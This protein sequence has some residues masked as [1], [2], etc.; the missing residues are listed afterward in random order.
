[1]L[2]V[3]WLRSAR[4]SSRGRTRQVAK[5][6]IVLTYSESAMPARCRMGRRCL[7]EAEGAPPFR[8]ILSEAAL[9][10]AL[11]STEEWRDQLEHLSE[12]AERPN[13][14]LQVLPQSA[15]LPDSVA[16]REA[17][18]R[19]LEGTD[20]VVDGGMRLAGHF[21][22]AQAVPGP[23]AAPGGGR[24]ERFE[25]ARVGAGAALRGCGLRRGYPPTGDNR[26]RRVADDD[27]VPAVSPGD[28]VLSVK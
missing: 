6:L 4:A 7:L 26:P 23:V 24:P 28:A 5:S 8:T 2:G 15:G 27:V 16:F 21:R 22:P 13:L 3:M 18:R 17:A 9:R 25:A 19:P 14:T 10:T 11:R 20:A 1:M 12:M